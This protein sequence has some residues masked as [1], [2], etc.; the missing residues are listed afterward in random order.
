MSDLTRCVLNAHAQNPDLEQDTPEMADAVYDL[1]TAA[2]VL[3]RQ[4][5]AVEELADR[6]DQLAREQDE[7]GNLCLA[8]AVGTDAARIRHALR[9]AHGEARP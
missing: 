1:A 2:P 6:L 9:D 4:V 3:A 8:G 5:E 7:A